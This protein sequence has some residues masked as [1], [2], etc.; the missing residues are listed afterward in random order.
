[1]WW[2]TVVSLVTSRS[3]LFRKLAVTHPWRRCFFSIQNFI[4]KFGDFLVW[5]LAHKKHL[6]TFTG[7]GIVRGNKWIQRRIYRVSKKSAFKCSKKEYLYHERAI[8]TIKKSTFLVLYVHHEPRSTDNLNKGQIFLYLG[9]SR[10]CQ[11]RSSLHH[12]SASGYIRNLK[13]V[14]SHLLN[15]FIPFRITMGVHI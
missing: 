2:K 6:I 4:G 10:Y 1:M 15:H 7:T 5:R 9:V 13:H 11:Q 14:S 12:P 3:K 8:H